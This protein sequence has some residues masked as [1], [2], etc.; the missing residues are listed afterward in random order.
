MGDVVVSTLPV[1]SS[2]V[3]FVPVIVIAH[4]RVDG[5][6]VVGRVDALVVGSW[7]SLALAVSPTGIGR[8]LLRRTRVRPRV[9]ATAV[10]GR[11]PIGCG[12]WIV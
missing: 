9:A 7:L 3:P 1:C 8:R 11:A 12:L 4:V 5:L 10:G 2:V 6:V